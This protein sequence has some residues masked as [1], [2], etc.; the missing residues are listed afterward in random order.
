MT[1]STSETIPATDVVTIDSIIA[2]PPGTEWEARSPLKE[3]R[4]K[5]PAVW[6]RVH[7]ALRCIKSSNALLIGETVPVASLH[8]LVSFRVVVVSYW[9]VLP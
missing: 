9:R 2:A 4:D 5:P 3:D 6:R 1:M 7:G 8:D